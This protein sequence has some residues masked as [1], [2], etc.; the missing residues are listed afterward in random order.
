MNLLGLIHG[1]FALINLVTPVFLGESHYSFVFLHSGLSYLMLLL[2]TVGLPK[3]SQDYL[4]SLLNS[5]NLQYVMYCMLFG[6]TSVRAST[7]FHVAFLL[8]RI[9]LL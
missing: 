1:A 6:A 8:L 9:D 3:F 5:E 2:Q 4:R 7:F